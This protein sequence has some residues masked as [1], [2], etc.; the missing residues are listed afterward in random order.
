MAYWWHFVSIPLYKI[1]FNDVAKGR[2]GCNILFSTSLRI[3][4]ESP[5]QSVR[6]SKM[7]SVTYWSLAFLIHTNNILISAAMVCKRSSFGLNGRFFP[8][9][10]DGLTYAHNLI[11]KL[12]FRVLRHWSLRDQGCTP[13]PSHTFPV[14]YHA[15]AQ[16]RRRHSKNMRGGLERVDRRTTTRV[17]I[18]CNVLNL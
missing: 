9:G 8:D 12:H 18:Y 17:L 1:P 13:M 11:S 2:V 3:L 7:F 10:M 4:G 14:L 16:P 6:G 5:S 15:S